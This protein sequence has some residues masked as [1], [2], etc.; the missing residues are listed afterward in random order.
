MAAVEEHGEDEIRGPEAY[1]CADGVAWRDG[2]S[3]R[4]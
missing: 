3:E 2:F 4:I 1:V